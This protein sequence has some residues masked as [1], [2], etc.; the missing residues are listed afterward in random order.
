MVKVKANNGTP[1][2]V[3]NTGDQVFINNI[4]FKGD[5][6][7]LGENRFHVLYENKS[8]NISVESIDKVSK[9][10]ILNIN[11]KK[12]T[13]TLQDELDELLVKMGMAS[14]TNHL[15]NELKAPMPGLVLKVMV[16]EGDEVKKGDGLLILE[17][18]KMENILKSPGAGVVKKLHVHEK[19]KIEKGQLLISF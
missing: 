1:Y 19:D 6:I 10:C 17:A 4:A 9:T 5:I 7:K 18:M 15:L 14:G 13:F 3:K 11:E 12:I 8:Y 16:N 2:E